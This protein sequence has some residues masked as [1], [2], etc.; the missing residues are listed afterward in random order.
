ME[1]KEKSC[2][3]LV[4]LSVASSKILT[5]EFFLTVTFLTC[6]DVYQFWEPCSHLLG[7]KKHKHVLLNRDQWAG[8]WTRQL[9]RSIGWIIDQK[10][11]KQRQASYAGRQTGYLNLGWIAN[12]RRSECKWTGWRWTGSW[13][14]PCRA[15]AEEP[16]E[17]ES[18][19]AE[20]VNKWESREWDG[21]YSR[22]IAKRHCLIS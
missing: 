22:S 16:M 10:L 5:R 2:L 15:N 20:A 8:R 12:R 3:V 14:E 13:G 17:A 11:E 4:A 6:F 21:G 18:L 7:R 9:A 19:F 1:R